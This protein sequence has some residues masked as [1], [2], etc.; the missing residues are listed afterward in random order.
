MCV[1]TEV[2]WVNQ[3]VVSLDLL[4][5]APRRECFFFVHD[6]F[7]ALAVGLR[8]GAN[9]IGLS[10]WFVQ[11]ICKGFCILG[12]YLFQY[13]CSNLLGPTWLTFVSGGLTSERYVKRVVRIRTLW[14][15]TEAK[16]MYGTVRNLTVL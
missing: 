1:Y 4:W 2:Q 10:L 5:T 8:V 15:G 9:I 11:K 16:K 14:Y 6:C 7:W 13:D 12:P 3:W